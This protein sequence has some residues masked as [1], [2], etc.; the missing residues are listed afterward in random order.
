MG[1]IGNLIKKRGH[2]TR[3]N[4]NEYPTKIL[5]AGPEGKRERGK[6]KLKWI[7]AMVEDKNK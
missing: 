3:M 2:A 5:S 1:N 4:E 6:K 7:D